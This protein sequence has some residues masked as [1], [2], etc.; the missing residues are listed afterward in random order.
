[1]EDIDNIEEVWKDTKQKQKNYF[2]SQLILKEII[3]NQQ[4]TEKAAQTIR[5][6]VMNNRLV[7]DPEDYVAC[8]T[9]TPYV[10]RKVP[11]RMHE[12]FH[13]TIDDYHLLKGKGI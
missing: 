5:Q 9:K 1:M 12:M 4:V 13:L 7:D 3:A 8:N 10:V 11:N 6:L 2:S